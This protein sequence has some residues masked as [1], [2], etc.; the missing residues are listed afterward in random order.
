MQLLV[1][2][3]L[4]PARLDTGKDQPRHDRLVRVARDQ[5]LSVVA[6]DREHRSLYRQRAA[7]GGEEGVVGAHR[8]G[9]QRLGLAEIPVRRPA[10]VQSA[11]REDIGAKRIQA[12]HVDDPVVHATPLP[13]PRRREAVSR[14]ASV[15]GQAG[16]QGVSV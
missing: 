16:Q 10:V 11:G 6:G 7:A 8:I 2:A 13:M 4:D 12:Q 3:R 5:Q 1:V 15:V 14:A 9:H